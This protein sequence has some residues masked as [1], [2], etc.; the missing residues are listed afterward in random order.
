VRRLRTGEQS[1]L[2]KRVEDLERDELG[3]VEVGAK[4]RRIDLSEHLA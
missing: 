3:R 2:G 1:G 4:C